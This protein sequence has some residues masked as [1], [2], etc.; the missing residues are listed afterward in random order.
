[1]DSRENTFNYEALKIAAKFDP[2]AARFLSRLECDTYDKF[3]M[4][5]YKDIE[6]ILALIEKTASLRQDDGEDRL[7]IEIINI[8]IGAG[9]LASHDQ[10]INGHSD[11]VVSFNSFT[12]IGEAK[13]HSSYDYLMEGFMQLCDRY[14]TGN[15]DDC[16]GGLIFYIKGNNALEVVERW[17]ADLIT[18][19]VPELKTFNC[20]NRKN[21]SFYSTHTHSKSGLPYK[22]RHFGVILGFNP[23][24]KS[25]R[26]AKKNN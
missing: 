17:K 21:L 23:T 22:V 4:M 16:E 10:Y 11:I 25:A 12:W 5:L 6:F 8:L 18:R 24:D 9:Y 7:S 3:I 14:S 26:G 15:E 1:M 20:N 19:N 2:M 13:I